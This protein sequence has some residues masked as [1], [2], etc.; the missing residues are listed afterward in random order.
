M[1]GFERVKREGAKG[2]LSTTTTTPPPPP[3]SFHFTHCKRY[4]TFISLC[5][6]CLCVFG[7]CQVSTE[8][9]STE[10]TFGYIGPLTLGNWNTAVTV[11]C[12]ARRTPLAFR[13]YTISRKWGRRRGK[14]GSR[15]GDISHYKILL[16]LLY[17]YL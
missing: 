6:L 10:Y 12:A 3:P 15:E 16:P 7:G 4:K 2:G 8:C 13:L 17:T 5:V 9:N 14:R 11:P 1:R